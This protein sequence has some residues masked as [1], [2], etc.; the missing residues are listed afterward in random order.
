[1]IGILDSGIGGL[2]VVNALKPLLP[3]F[4]MVY[5]GD[6]AHSPYGGK[7]PEKIRQFADRGMNFLA[8]QGAKMVVVACSTI[9]SVA[10]GHFRHT[11]DLPVLEAVGPAA[12]AAMN[13]RARRNTI[14]VIGTPG[15]V[16][17]RA[18]EKK[19]RKL[20]PNAVVYAVAAPMLVPLIESGLLKRPE[21]AMIVKKYLHALKIK[22]VDTLI[23]GCNHYTVIGKLIQHKMGKRVHLIDSVSVLAQSVR[24]YVMTHQEIRRSLGKNGFCRYCLSDITDEMKQQARNIFRCN[25]NLEM[26]F[27]DSR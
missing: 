2:T 13:L 15:T 18:H 22:N 17:S 8:N 24:T 16:L 3:G 7:S 4:D 25:G 20:L 26:V 19:I 10:A 23:M 14:G 12:L 27:L 9:S 11:Y 21:T 5:L 6:T 1:M